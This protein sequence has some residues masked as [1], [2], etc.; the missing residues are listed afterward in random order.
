[1]GLWETGYTHKKVVSIPSES[2]TPD[3]QA[4][5]DDYLSYFSYTDV[6]SLHFFDESS[7][8]KTSGKRT[9]GSSE[10]GKLAIEIQPCSSNANFTTNLLQSTRSIDYFNVMEVPSN[11]QEL[12]NIFTEALY[13]RHS[14][15]SFKL[16]NGDVVVMDNCGFHHGHNT[17]PHFRTILAD[18]K[19]SL[20][21]QPPVFQ[22]YFEYCFSQLKS[23]LSEHEKY[24]RELTEMAIF[25][26]LLQKIDRKKPYQS[27]CQEVQCYFCTPSLPTTPKLWPFQ[28]GTSVVV[29]Y[30]SC[31]LCLYFGS[32]IMLVTYF[33]NFR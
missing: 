21:F 14:D 3:C 2:Q 32:S 27:V 25:D 28:C 23:F 19:I 24:A 13:V 15:G 5:Y 4:K 20:V 1:M 29:P 12:L 30:C 26:G 33:V 8:T 7:V 22:N 16:C 9:Y 18:R 10:V 6:H 11:G 17:K 31:C